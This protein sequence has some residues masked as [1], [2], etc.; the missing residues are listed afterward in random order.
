[1]KDNLKFRF[2]ETEQNYM[3]HEIPA[4]PFSSNFKMMIGC[5]VNGTIVYDGDLLESKSEVDGEKIAS[6]IPV[7]FENGAMWVDESFHKDGSYLHLLAEW[8]EPIKV[9]GNIYENL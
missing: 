1:M 2:W 4:H 5:E 3:I 8:D 9:I 6:E 7:I